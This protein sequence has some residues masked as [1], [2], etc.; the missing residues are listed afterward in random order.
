M[1]I[2]FVGQFSNS[3][4][5]LCPISPIFKLHN[6]LAIKI[7]GVKGLN[8]LITK[9]EPISFTDGIRSQLQL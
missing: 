3:R 5:T 6:I 4:L 1:D 7:A 2:Q 8:I 9:S